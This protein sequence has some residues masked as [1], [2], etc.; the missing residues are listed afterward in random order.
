MGIITKGIPEQTALDLADKYNLTTFVE[1]GTHVGKTSLF[2]SQWFNEVYTIES[3]KY[4][5]NIAKAKMPS[6]VKL[7]LGSSQMWLPQIIKQLHNPALFWLD[8]HWSRDLQ[9]EKPH[10][11]CPVLQ[12]IRAINKFQYPHVI[13][14]DDARL[15]GN[16]GWPSLDNV[17][18]SLS[19]NRSNVWIEDDV[20][21]AV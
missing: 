3:V 17:I 11:I 21:F 13:M 9:G 14:V 2:A 19:H 7:Y 18:L 1:S 5:H 15:F 20:I 4:Y 10:V 12:E 6:N 8:A 16:P